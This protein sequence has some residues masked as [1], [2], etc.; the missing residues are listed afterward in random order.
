MPVLLNCFV[1]TM[2]GTSLKK[3]L[4]FSGH[5]EV[6]THSCLYFSMSDSVSRTSFFQQLSVD[7]HKIHKGTLK[8]LVRSAKDP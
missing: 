2:V 1:L 6:I 3:V 8:I 7:L 5:L 4:N